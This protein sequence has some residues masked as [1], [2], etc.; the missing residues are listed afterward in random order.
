VTLEA[1]ETIQ[2][3]GR[4]LQIEFLTKANGEKVAQVKELSQGSH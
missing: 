3:A 2:V 4:T 1:G